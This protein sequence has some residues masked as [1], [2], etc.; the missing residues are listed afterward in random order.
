VKLAPVIV[1]SPLVVK[2]SAA[3]ISLTPVAPGRE[4][5]AMRPSTL[6]VS[7][8]KASSAHADEAA[9][10]DGAATSRNGFKFMDSSS[11]QTGRGQVAHGLPPAR[12]GRPT[13][14]LAPS[15]H[16]PSFVRGVRPA[17][18]PQGTDLRHRPSR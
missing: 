10:I 15:N 11:T 8:T 1:V 3:S 9:R 2:S 18:I 13:V 12:G 7:K 5:T 4:A 17:G 6:P 14:V 16:H